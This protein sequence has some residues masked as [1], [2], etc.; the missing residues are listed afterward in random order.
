MLADIV[1]ASS[2][3][4]SEPTP[5]R[6]KG[7]VKNLIEG[8]LNDGQLDECRLTLVELDTIRNSF[9]NT[10]NSIFHQRIEYPKNDKH[11]TTKKD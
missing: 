11:N 1:E 7:L 8:V 4:L 5:S 6:I 2:R 9:T 3:T 10:L